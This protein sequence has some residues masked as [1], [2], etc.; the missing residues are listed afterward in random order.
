MQIAAKCWLVC[1]SNNCGVASYVLSAVVITTNLPCK[2]FALLEWWMEYLYGGDNLGS[3]GYFW[4]VFVWLD[5]VLK[6]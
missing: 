4:S 6:M 3:V 1:S 5:V 2:E